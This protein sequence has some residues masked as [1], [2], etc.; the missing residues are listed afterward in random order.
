MASLIT[1]DWPSNYHNTPKTFLKSPGP[2]P[3]SIIMLTLNE[4]AKPPPQKKNQINF[5]LSQQNN[6]FVFTS[7]AFSR[8][9]LFDFFDRGK[10]TWANIAICNHTVGC[11]F[12]QIKIACSQYLKTIRRKWITTTSQQKHLG[13]AK[14]KI[15]GF[16]GIICVRFLVETIAKNRCYFIWISSF[17][18]FQMPWVFFK[19]MIVW[20]FVLVRIMLMNMKIL[21]LFEAT[22]N[23]RSNNNKEEVYLKGESNL[24]VVVISM[25]PSDDKV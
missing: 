5:R 8:Y 1:A 24:H 11:V 16:L 12:A 15:P 13:W 4:A 20:I 21:R 22:N 10:S 25:F 23:P 2:P 3:Q 19:H 7:S 6:K 18:F 9:L 14:N 17:V